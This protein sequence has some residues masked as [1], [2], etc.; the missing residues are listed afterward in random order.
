MS[1]NTDDR[2]G[3]YEVSSFPCRRRQAR[4][5]LTLTLVYVDFGADN[6]G[7]VL[8]LSEDGFSVQAAMPLAKDSFSSMRFRGDRDG[9]SIEVDGR[10]VWMSN[11]RKTAGIQ[12]VALSEGARK[13]IAEWLVLEVPPVRDNQP[14]KND[15]L[16]PTKSAPSVSDLSC[17]S[18][19][20]QS[21]ICRLFSPMSREWQRE[22]RD[23]H[24]SK[25]PHPV[26]DETSASGGGS[27]R[28]DQRIPTD[29]NAP[30]S[31]DRSRGA[32]NEVESI[33]RSQLGFQAPDGQRGDL[34]CQPAPSNRAPI[35]RDPAPEVPQPEMDQLGS[36]LSG[37]LTNDWRH[38]ST[39]ESPH[40]VPV[41][42]SA[43]ESIFSQRRDHRKGTGDG[44]SISSDRSRH[45]PNGEAIPGSQFLGVQTPDASREDPPSA[46]AQLPYLNALVLIVLFGALTFTAGLVLGRVLLD[47]P[48]NGASKASLRELPGAGEAAPATTVDN[49]MVAA[50]ADTPGLNPLVEALEPN[51]ADGNDHERSAAGPRGRRDEAVARSVLVEPS[52]PHST[53]AGPRAS[54]NNLLLSAKL[55][56]GQR[57]QPVP[58]LVNS[59]VSHLS[60][61][62]A[63]VPAHTTQI[64]DP[65]VRPK[66]TPPVQSESALSTAGLSA[67]PSP[68]NVS[69][70]SSASRASGTEGRLEEARIVASATLGHT[71]PC[72]LI[73]PVQP[74]YPREAEEQRLEGDVELRVVVGTDGTVR[75][76]KVVSGPPLLASAAMDAARGFRYSPALLNGQPIEAIQTVAV[77]FRLKR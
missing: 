49:R 21:E 35:V 58:Q 23:S 77:S 16:E 39:S 28:G 40:L 4:Q 72:R 57:T 17:N 56:R 67:I 30:A 6:G 22:Q 46:R 38:S 61:P 3:S 64:S 48:S 29:A 63:P 73:H 70:S 59:P 75:S 33:I 7:I 12:F 69:G 36:P 42:A 1:T 26:P 51:R 11:T 18:E 47:R 25:L 54:P 76:V 24:A 41:G 19:Q 15:A 13:R 14:T 31:N 37:E 27:Q 9:D 10:L 34:P 44:A 50:R 45:E 32:L 74:L 8:N 65:H 60:E 66:G 55:R 20:T 68:G 71:D 43:C 62:L 2:V 52:S 53:D 5:E